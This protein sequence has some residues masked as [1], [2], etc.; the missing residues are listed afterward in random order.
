MT[1]MTARPLPTALP[2]RPRLRAFKLTVSALCLYYGIRMMLVGAMAFDFREPTDFER[3][4]L[5]VAVIL[6]ALMT[7]LLYFTISMNGI[8]RFLTMFA[9]TCGALFAL[10][11]ADLILFSFAVTGIVGATT[12]LISFAFLN[13]A[14]ETRT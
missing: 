8:L 4:F 9:L 3:T 12:T 6:L 14:F 7:M 13:E 1:E 2:L 10:L 11:N 5:Y